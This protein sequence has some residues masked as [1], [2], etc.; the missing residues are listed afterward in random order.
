MQS[1]HPR[2]VQFADESDEGYEDRVLIRTELSSNSLEGL[3]AREQATPHNVHDWLQKRQSH[4]QR[5]PR[6][7]EHVVHERY[8]GEDREVLGG[9]AQ[10]V[11]ECLIW[12]EVLVHQGFATVANL[13]LHLRVYAK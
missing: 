8:L 2:E 4:R 7:A 1:N 11:A 10:K 12:F 5:E 3:T 9:R 13:A 6:A